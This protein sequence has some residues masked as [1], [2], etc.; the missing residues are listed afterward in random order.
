MVH[1][2]WIG[3]WAFP[4][5]D[6]LLEQSGRR[7]EQY[8]FEKIAA[9]IIDKVQFEKDDSVLDVCCGNA[10]LTRYIAR[11]CKEIHGVDHSE[12][13]MDAARKLELKE[14]IYNL[15]LHF[16][17]VMLIDKFFPENF[18]DKSYC[19]FSFQYFT[20]S[21]REKILEK[22]SRVTKNKGW[23][24][25]GDVPDKTRMWN[26]YESPA[27]FYRE[28]LF[29]FLR[30]KKGECFLGW[31]INPK[32]ILGWCEKNNLNASIIPQDATLPHA[33]YRFDVLIRN[34]KK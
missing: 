34:S 14:N 2:A 27:K 29:R 24:F 4:S 18:F 6:S 26:Y 21:K 11:A 3:K 9:D 5:D 8:N 30:G 19:Y 32:E 31:W 33:Y 23:I 28:K 22:L 15:R 17:D 7:G 20:K 16:S 25:I 12:L 1:D 13:L 10:G